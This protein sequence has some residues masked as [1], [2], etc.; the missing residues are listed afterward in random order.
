MFFEF[1]YFRL[2]TQAALKAT[3]LKDDPYLNMSS[4]VN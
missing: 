3:N 1:C 2:P 4:A